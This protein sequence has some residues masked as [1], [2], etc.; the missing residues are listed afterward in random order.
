MLQLKQF[1]TTSTSTTSTKSTP[2]FDDFEERFGNEETDKMNIVN[3][4]D[5]EEYID[6]K[7]K[8]YLP[9]KIRNLLEYIINDTSFNDAERPMIGDDYIE[10]EKLEELIQEEIESTSREKKKS[11]LED[12]L[13]FI[14]I[15]HEFNDEKSKGFYL[16]LEQNGEDY[17]EDEQ[18]D[19]YLASL[20]EKDNDCDEPGIDCEDDADDNN[21]D[22]Y[23]YS[24]EDN[25]Y[26]SD[27]NNSDNEYDS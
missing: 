8:N 19:D 14:N 25:E 1:T 13:Q 10:L 21:Y 3:T 11:K 6:G 23:D 4:F 20:Y 15:K 5:V 24:E 26:D 16:W 27:N 7:Y 9:K 12:L 17:D 2:M 18:I 22:D